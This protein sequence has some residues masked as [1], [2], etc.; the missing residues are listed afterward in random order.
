MS[1]TKAERE[2]LAGLCRFEIKRWSKARDKQYMV[3]LMQLAMSE[4]TEGWRGR[5]EVAESRL[6]SFP[7]KVGNLYNGWMKAEA[8]R[9]EVRAQLETA[10][11]AIDNLSAERD[12]LRAQVEDE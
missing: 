4:L 10:K 7:E 1:H 2:A 6:S 9:D 12:A 8:E 3:D 11:R 5:A